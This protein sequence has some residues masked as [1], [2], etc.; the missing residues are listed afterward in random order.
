M[1]IVRWVLDS[2]GACL[3]SE[4]RMRLESEREH[5]KNTVLVAG[6]DPRDGAI[7]YHHGHE[8]VLEHMEKGIVGLLAALNGETRPVLATIRG[9]LRVAEMPNRGDPTETGDD[10][11]VYHGQ[12]LN[13]S[14]TLARPKPID[15][16]DE[17]L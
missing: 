3:P 5:Y 11:G 2:A 7:L 9:S 13:W 6:K 10:K 17:P 16:P 15:Q 1:Q 8:R 12:E 4:M 14:L